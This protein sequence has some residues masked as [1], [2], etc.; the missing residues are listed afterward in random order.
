MGDDHA[1][2]VEAGTAWVAEHDGQV[3]GLV[4]LLPKKD[5]LLLDNIAVDPRRAG[6]GHGRALLAFAEAH[7]RKLGFA[8]LRLYTN[9]AM[10]ENVAHYTK[11]GWQETGRAGQDGFSRVFF[12]KPV[13]A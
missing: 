9:A 5:H 6:Q 13:S 7:A 2:R 1:A 10:H 3:I 12:R 11:S 8:E 4:V